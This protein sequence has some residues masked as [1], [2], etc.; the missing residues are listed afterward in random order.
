MS[1]NIVNFPGA[2]LRAEDARFTTFYANNVSMHASSGLEQIT[3]VG[4]V[5]T[6]GIEISNIKPSTSS[7]TGALVVAGG[8][9]VAGNVT[10]GSNL[11]VTDETTL[12]NLTVTE[13]TLANLSVT[14]ETVEVANLAVTSGSLELTRVSNLFQIKSSSNVVT[15]FKRSKKLI[16]YP[17]KVLNYLA[18]SS[19]YGTAYNASGYQGYKV[20]RSSNYPGYEDWEAF[21]NDIGAEGTQLW[22]S[23]TTASAGPGYDGYDN[24]TFVALTNNPNGQHP[25]AAGNG[26]WIQI[27]LPSSI[28]PHTL[29]MHPRSNYNQNPKTFVFVASEDNSNW[30]VLI[31]NGQAS[32]DWGANN[33]S[34]GEWEMDS[35]R[36]YK[37]FAVIVTATFAAELCAIKEIEILGI[38]EYDPEAHGTDTIMRS[39][40]NVPNTD[41][42]E[43]YY[44]ANDY[45]SMPATI[46]DKSGNGVTGTPNN[47]VT[48]DSTWKAFVFNASTPSTITTSSITT[49]GGDLPHSW[50]VWIKPEDV[51]GSTKTYMSVFALGLTDGGGGN[52][53]PGLTLAR[54]QKRMQF[55]FNNNNLLFSAPFEFGKWVHVVLTYAGGGATWSNRKIYVNGIE[56]MPTAI[57][58][59]AGDLALSTSATLNVGTTWYSGDYN[60]YNGALANLRFHDRV[61]T[62]DEA[63]QL[64]AYQKEYFQVSPDVVTLKGGR[65]GIGTE[66][67]RAVLDVRGDTFSK[68]YNGGRSTFLTWDYLGSRSTSF[69]QPTTTSGGTVASI[70]DHEF[71]IPSCYHDLG[72][73]TLKAYIKVDWR[74][75]FNIPWNFLFRLKVYYND[76][77]STYTLDSSMPDQSA[78]NRGRG[79]GLPTVSYHDN[80]DSTPEAASVTSQFTLKECQVSSGSKIKV[81][82]LG[83]YTDFGGGAAT[84]WTGR[85]ANAANNLGFE[86]MTSSFFVALD[87]V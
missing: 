49:S 18:G 35:L 54:D 62:P 32:G 60:N 65:L 43:V 72:T 15:E 66:Q 21:D 25:S 5:T 75:E 10:V 14:G 73:T 53:M 79:C 52:T 3:A 77:S 64:Y 68:M 24:T 27:E 33:A 20:T 86:M 45:T 11:S 22:A 57:I 39:V 55:G 8:V 2:S 58:G 67:P 40:P 26:D 48:F 28:Y 38:P 13:A 29:R 47:G 70:L 87:V 76:Y 51:S 71:N 63:W 1:Q 37:Y 59:T 81:E 85:C 23:D 31:Q 61:L 16:K 56:C 12:S 84:L 41:W 9:G 6:T 78:D 19:E 46:T 50:S 74:G 17:R 30:D 80:Y 82:L 34:W 36:K 42:L 7:T 4:H 44:D 69:A 83:V